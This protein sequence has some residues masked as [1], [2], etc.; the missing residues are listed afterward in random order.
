M[1]TYQTP[2]VV[3]SSPGVDVKTGFIWVGAHDRYLYGLDV[4]RKECHMRVNCREGSCF[5][6]PAISYDPHHVYVGTLAGYFLCIDAVSGDVKWLKRFKKP[7]FSSPLIQG[8]KIFV[9]TVNGC[10]RCLNHCGDD[11]WEFTTHGSIFSSPL[12]NCRHGDDVI[13]ASHAQ[14]VYCISSEGK[15]KWSTLVDGPVYATPCFAFYNYV[16]TIQKSSS[17]AHCVHYNNCVIIVTTKGTIYLLAVGDGRV[18][19]MFTL[20]GEIF[21]SPVTVGDDIVIGCRNDYLYCLKVT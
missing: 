17:P 11:F 20:P 9:A 2:D 7:I 4:D 8:N 14:K 12:G 15:R 19:K 5:S 16:S 21:S 3:K 18:L 6:S 10:L 13:L 1:W